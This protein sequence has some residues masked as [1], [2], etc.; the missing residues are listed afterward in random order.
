MTKAK[1]YQWRDSHNERKNHKKTEKILNEKIT[2]AEL[3]DITNTISKAIENTNAIMLVTLC[4]LIQ[5]INKPDDDTLANYM[6]RRGYGAKYNTKDI[7][8]WLRYLW[9]ENNDLVATGKIK[10][11]ENNI[12]QL[13]NNIKELNKE[14]IN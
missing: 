8:R 3:I 2:R 5:T 6:H 9:H 10:E 13:N 14:L 1:I 7:E 4:M 12:I 11:L